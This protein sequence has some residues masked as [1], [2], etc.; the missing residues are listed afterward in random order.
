MIFV[1]NKDL[2][3]VMLDDPFYFFSKMVEI[4][5]QL[6]IILYD[7]FFQFDGLLGQ[8]DRALLPSCFQGHQLINGDVTHADKLIFLHPEV[9]VPHADLKISTSY[10][11]RFDLN[12]K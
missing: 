9:M 6:E 3:F 4:H 12:M 1:S 10:K 7:L 2:G 11:M 8:E 5:V